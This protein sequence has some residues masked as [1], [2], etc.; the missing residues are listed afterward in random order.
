[1]KKMMLFIYIVSGRCEEKKGTVV[2]FLLS[3]VTYFIHSCVHGAVE[4]FPGKGVYVILYIFP[5]FR[6]DKKKTPEVIQ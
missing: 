3:C 2:K 5:V 4:Y 1:M 6:Y